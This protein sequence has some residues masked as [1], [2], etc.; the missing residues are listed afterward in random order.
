MHRFIHTLDT[1]PKNW[2]LELEMCRETRIW[3]ELVQIFKVKFTFEHVSSLIDVVLQ[4]IQTKIFLVEEM[5]EVVLVCN[6]H[7]ASLTV[8]ELLECYNVA[9]EEHD[10][11]DPK[12]VQVP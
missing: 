8:Y 4:D 12:N 6:A 1:I 3:D 7:K 11:E 9:K 10:E 5:I 2:Y